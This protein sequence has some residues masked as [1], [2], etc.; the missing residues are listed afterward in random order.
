MGIGALG[1][2][3]TRKVKNKDPT[4]DMSGDSPLGLQLGSKSAVGSFLL[5]ARQL[6]A[7]SFATEAPSG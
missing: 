7:G 3:I 6:M 1:P 5:G 4:E 2:G